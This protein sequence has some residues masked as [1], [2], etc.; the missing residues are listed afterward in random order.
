M[1]LPIPSLLLVDFFMVLSIIAVLATM[2]ANHRRLPIHAWAVLPPAALLVIALTAA[3]V[4]GDPLS[5]ARTRTESHVGDSARE[6][7]GALPLVGRLTISLTVVTVIVIGVAYR[8]NK[9]LSNI[10]VRRIMYAWAIGTAFSGAYTVVAS[11]S[12]GKL[13]H[14]SEM[15]FFSYKSSQTRDSG[16]AHH[17]VVLGVSV[18][19]A[20]PLLMYMASTL[21]GFPKMAVATLIPVSLYAIYLSGSRGGLLLAALLISSTFAYQVISRKRIGVAALLS[22]LCMPGFAILAFP[23]LRQVAVEGTRFFREDG[24]QSSDTRLGKIRDGVDMFDSNPFFGAG[25]GIWPG[26]FVPLILLTSGG[27]LYA[28]IY[29]GSLAWP[30]LKSRKTNSGDFAAIL[31]ITASG[32]LVAGL[33]NNAFVDRYLYWPFAALF[34]LA[35]SSTPPTVPVRATEQ[36]RHEV[37]GQRQ[38]LRSK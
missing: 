31:L 20:L 29:Y 30:L 12:V 19:L 9:N 18:A 26:E 17:P 24:Q 34:V 16:L 10:L 7:A 22:I 35:L 32:V 21:R 8:K 36:N 6:L 11:S 5:F 2:A 37:G 25:V 4:R 15:P 1:G 38:P 13:L 28:A 33:L 14:L 23:H 3:V 27:V